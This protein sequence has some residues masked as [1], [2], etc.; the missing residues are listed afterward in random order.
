MKVICEAKEKRLLCSSPAHPDQG[1]PRPARMTGEGPA[2]D[3]AA[4]GA[5]GEEG[6]GVWIS[7][8]L[9]PPGSSF[10]SKDIY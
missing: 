7:R 9:L 5:A 4:A 6:E 3:P 8:L 10:H 2:Q 1:G